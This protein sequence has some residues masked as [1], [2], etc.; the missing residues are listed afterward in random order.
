[1]HRVS[2]RDGAQAGGPAMRL[3]SPPLGP[4]GVAQGQVISFAN[5]PCDAPV[6]RP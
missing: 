3:T 5:L 4:G 2:N 6:G 1:M